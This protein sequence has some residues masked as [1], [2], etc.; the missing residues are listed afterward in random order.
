[1]SSAP[2]F[3]EITVGD[4]IPEATFGPLSIGDTVR[5]AGS[6]EIWERLHFDREYARGHSGQRTFIASGAY[7][8]AMLARMLTDWIGPRGVLRKLR[9]RH[10]APTLEGDLMRFC[11]RVVEKSPEAAD[12]WLECELEGKNQRD[13]RIVIGS[14]VVVLGTA[15]F[16]RPGAERR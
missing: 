13:E 16:A 12:P 9:L 5:W 10:T 15:G 6:Q 7:R 1:M 8:Q 14:C 11:G 4:V 2:A 3:A